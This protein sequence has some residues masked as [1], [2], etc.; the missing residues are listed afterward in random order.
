[1]VTRFIYCDN[2]SNILAGDIIRKCWHEEY[3]AAVDVE[4]DLREK[5]AVERNL[6]NRCLELPRDAYT[7]TQ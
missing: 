3:N 2:S 6:P 4:K 5:L 7:V 1:M